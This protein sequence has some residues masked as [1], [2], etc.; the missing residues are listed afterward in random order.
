MREV[1]PTHSALLDLRQEREGMQEG[2]QFLDEKRLVL[3]AEMVRELQHYEL[4]RRRLDELFA[5]AQSA[6][7]AAVERHGLQGLQI[8]P[9][10]G[11]RA[12]QPS[13][14]ER[15]VLGVLLQSASVAAGDGAAATAVYSSPEA[16]LC[17]RVF[18]G[19]LP[20]IVETAAVSGNLQRLRDEYRHTARRARALED[21]LIPEIDETLASLELALEDLDREEVVRARHRQQGGPERSRHP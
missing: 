13:V 11:A 2:Y 14:A 10:A 12:A 7:Q 21:V 17:R 3:A 16:E 5:E 6:L 4:I 19:L 1:V 15:S 18:T 9:V 20:A 8:Y